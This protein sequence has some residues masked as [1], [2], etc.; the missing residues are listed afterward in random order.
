M[1]KYIRSKVNG[2]IFDY[3]ARLVGNPNAEIITE[4][5][6]YPERFR[7]AELEKHTAKVSIQVPVEVTEAPNEAP[8]ALRAEAT[9]RFSKPATTKLKAA[10]KKV[11][12]GGLM[13]D[14]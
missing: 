9:E 4:A 1:K 10:P 13:G 12:L 5:E 8:D 6:A 14:F 3:D 11:D 7:P 2:I